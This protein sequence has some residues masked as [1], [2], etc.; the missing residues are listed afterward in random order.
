MIDVSALIRW[1]VMA[2]LTVY[3]N[4]RVFHK[5]WRTA[6]C[7]LETGVEGQY[8]KACLRKLTT[9]DTPRGLLV[10]AVNRVGADDGRVDFALVKVR[11]Q[12]QVGCAVTAQVAVG[13]VPKGVSYA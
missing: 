8:D 11:W 1:S 7:S 9:T 6:T 12:V 3:A 10:A 13:D 2:V 5:A 4:G